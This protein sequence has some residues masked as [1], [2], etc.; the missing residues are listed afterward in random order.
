M[1]YTV[2]EIYLTR[3]GEGFHQ[4]R[5]AVFVRFSGCNLWSGLEKDRHNA[6]CKF[7]D[8]DFVGT[9]GQYGGKFRTAHELTRAVMWVWSASMPPKCDVVTNLNFEPYVVFTGGEPSLQVDE[10][11]IKELKYFGFI[12]A[13]ETNG[14]RI[15][16]DGIDWI[17]VSP[18]AGTSLRQTSGN[19]LK[20][21]F[22][23]TDLDPCEYAQMDFGHYFLQPMDGPKVRENEILA[24]AYC[25]AHP[26]WNL[27]LQIQK[28]LDWR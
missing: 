17:C 4:G 19:E 21:V 6:I 25:K 8:T 7:C 28:V 22:P 11:L 20:I 1:S 26:Q 24:Q 12:V 5:L 13:I 18:K 15:L 16:P 27:S 23:Q 2:K 10:C 14:T 9:N 3:Q